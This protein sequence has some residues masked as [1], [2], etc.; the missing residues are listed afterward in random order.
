MKTINAKKIALLIAL[1]AAFITGIVELAFVFL[2]REGYS[3]LMVVSIVL[4]FIA[5]YLL[6][7]LLLNN[8]IFEKINPIYKTINKLEKSEDKLRKELD[9]K[10][11][12]DDLNREVEDWATDKTQEID[13]LKDMAKFRQEFLGNV[14]RELK[15]P[16]YN[17][18]EYIVALLNGG[19][20]DSSKNRLYLENAE[21]S[22]GKLVNIVEDLDIITQ[23]DSGGIKIKFENFDIVQL[24]REIFKLQE[25]EA[26]KQMINLDLKNN[27]AN[28]LM[29]HAD[30]Q[31]IQ[32]AMA[33]LV[34]N[35][36]KYGKKNGC[37]SVD[38]ID[39]EDNILVEV[40]DN[41]MGIPNEDLP[42]IFERFYRVDK[43]RSRNQEGTGLGLAIV[44]HIVEAHNQIINVKSQEDKGSCFA[45]TLR[46]G[47]SQA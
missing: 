23:L 13:Q 33:N 35:S 34:V 28:R 29:V 14:S 22:T 45:F 20:D 36:I 10:D 32:E 44:K 9:K 30:R 46:K 11:M 21:K 7:F 4:V 19:I 38:F 39:L 27:N 2:E 8:F 47:V 17:V 16:I 40:S 43:T 1:L 15:T 26:Q 5:V 31:R 42:R 3:T 25:K 18:Q 41:G 12:I 6:T 37:T 24:T